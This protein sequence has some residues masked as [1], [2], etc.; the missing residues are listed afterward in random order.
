MT[1][2]DQILQEMESVPEPVLAEVLGF[3]QFLKFRHT[4][5]KK[6]VT[7]VS[8]AGEVSIS[9]STL[10]IREPQI[11]EYLTTIPL[12]VSQMCE[13]LKQALNKNGYH[14]R[15]QIVGLV[16]EVK[17]EMLTEKEAKQANHA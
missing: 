17:Q 12:S 9:L 10:A 1:T 11:S 13:E 15:E 3:L 5:S 7:V 4:V 8:A 16:Q 2:R 6:S 14:S